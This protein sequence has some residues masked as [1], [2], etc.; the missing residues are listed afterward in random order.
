[1]NTDIRISLQEY[2]HEVKKMNNEIET[3]LYTLL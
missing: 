2:L 1:M 3:S